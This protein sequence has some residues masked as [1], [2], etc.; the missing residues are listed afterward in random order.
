MVY[1]LLAQEQYGVSLEDGLLCYTQ[2]REVVRIPQGRNENLM[3][4]NVTTSFIVRRSGEESKE[5]DAHAHAHVE[6]GAS[7]V[8]PTIDDERVCGRCYAFHTCVLYRQVGVSSVL[9]L[10][11]TFLF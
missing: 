11:L 5:T 1:S 8:L 10:M 2:S 7:F 9:M 6:E 4:M 3:A